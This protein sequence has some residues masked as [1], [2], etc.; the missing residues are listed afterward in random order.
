MP[1]I[2]IASINTIGLTRGTTVE[3]TRSGFIRVLAHKRGSRKVKESI[4]QANF[5]DYLTRGI[6][7]EMSDEAAKSWKPEVKG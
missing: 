5:K 1:C 7:M 4:I 3:Q 6:L 2:A